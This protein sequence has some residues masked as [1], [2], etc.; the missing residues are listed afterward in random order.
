MNIWSK[1]LVSNNVT[2]EFAM[3]RM[4]RI[5]SK[6]IIV[7]DKNKNYLGTLS[8]G[9]IRKS[10]LKSNDLKTTINKVFNKNTYYLKK[11][12]Y[13][14]VKVKNKLIK[15][16]YDIIP[17]IDKNN[18][19]V[20]IYEW[21]NLFSNKSSSIFKYKSIPVIIM[22]GGRGSR[23]MPFST[24]LP[25]PLI[26][27][28]NKTIIENI[29]DTFADKGM[30]NFTISVGFKSN[31]IKSFFEDYPKKNKKFNFISEKKPLGTAGCIKYFDKKNK[32]KNFVVTN[33][34]VLLD[35]DLSNFFDSH[36][37]NGYDLSIVASTKDFKLDYGVC[38]L[39]SD[40]LLNKI[41][42][43]PKMNFLVNCGMYILNNK[44]KKLIPL[45][46][47][48]EMTDLIKILIKKKYK[49][50]VFPIHESKWIDI[51]QWNKYE[52]SKIKK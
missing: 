10:I 51:G 35:I 52:E 17:V 45:N 39:N 12:K 43:K 1:F 3:K 8:D 19:V 15:E 23:L 50:G 36:I 29:I 28:R 37:R 18:K 46:K 41:V 13:D 31:I 38:E 25:K 4:N 16:K 20:N 5:G 21:N 30:N 7:V 47:Y 27:F 42:E 40:G 48:F 2:I 26:P 11:D 44:V 32:Y 34:D 14:L 6:S 9:D 49:V 33:C 24:I 22:A